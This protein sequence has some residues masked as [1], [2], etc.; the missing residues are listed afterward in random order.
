MNILMLN[1]NRIWE[2]TFNRAFYFGRSLANSGH[3]VTVVTNSKKNIF[4]FK[5]YDLEGVK[6]IETPDLLK[7]RLRTGWDPINAL[8]R[9]AY[10]K[11]KPFDI[12]HA[13][14]CRPTVIIPALHLKRAMDIPLVIDWADWWGRGGAIKLR[15]QKILNTL[16]EPVETFFE[17][18]FRKYADYTSVISPLL[19]ERAVGLGV[20]PQKIEVV[21]NGCDIE[22]IVPLDKTEARKKL[23][24][25]GYRFILLFSGFV[26]Y[27]VEMALKALASVLQSHP[28]TLLLLTG[29]DNPFKEVDNALWKDNK[30]ILSLGFLPKEKYNL[31]L[32]AS[33]LCL[34]PLSDTTAN[35]ARYPGRIGDYMAA[36]RPIVSNYVGVAA[37]IIKAYGLGKLTE[38]TPGRFADGIIEALD[39][40]DDREK[41]GYNARK[42]A[43][44]KLS[45][46]IV[47]KDIEKIYLHLKGDLR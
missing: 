34:M 13:F 18:R 43:E 11:S 6:I 42:A 3:A 37:D 38:S 40:A 8:R 47:G 16:F 5:E 14:D 32:G 41:W 10:L 31:A 20:N 2:S 35:R 22:G 30:N 9:I 33:D 26:L 28:N 44:D 24:F 45:Y 23:N 25:S 17:E 39:N 15:K 1:H 46:D 27:D 4:S 36:G 12:I 29:S 7:G 19:K 21:L